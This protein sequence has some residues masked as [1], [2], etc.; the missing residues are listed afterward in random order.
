MTSNPVQP[1]ALTAIHVDHPPRLDGTLDDPRWS[2]AKSHPLLLPQSEPDPTPAEAGRV[3]LIYDDHHLY[4]GLDFED[5]D[6]VQEDDR[7]HQHHYNTGDVAEIFLKPTAPG[8]THYWELYVAP[9]GCKS[10]L[11]FPGRGRLGLPGAMTPMPGLK[12]A[13]RVDGTLN[14]WQHEDRGWTAQMAV[15]FAAL[16]VHGDT[17]PGDEWSILVARYNYG[18]HLTRPE[19]T[20]CPRM[21]RAAWHDHEHWAPLRFAP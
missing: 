6:V 11:F 3:L 13:A 10:S 18:R 2:A 16:S 17:P 19:L 21:P 9:N 12:V 8:A 4:V 14:D 7:D 20:C 15:P 5:R 1:P